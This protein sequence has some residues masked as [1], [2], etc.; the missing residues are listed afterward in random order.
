MDWG[1]VIVIAGAAC[2]AKSLMD[3]FERMEKSAKK[4]RAAGANSYAATGYMK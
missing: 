2:L 3:I 1:L 4:D